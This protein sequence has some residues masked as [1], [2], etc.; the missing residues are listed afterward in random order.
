MHTYDPSATLRLCT[1]TCSECGHVRLGTQMAATDPGEAPH[2]V[3]GQCDAVSFE[4]ASDA[5]KEAWLGGAKPVH[6]RVG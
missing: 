5:Q 1:G 6:F 3:C 2:F 4:I